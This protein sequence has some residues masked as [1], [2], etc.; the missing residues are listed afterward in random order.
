MSRVLNACFAILDIATSVWLIKNCVAI[1]SQ[2]LKQQLEYLCKQYNSF[3]SS[4]V[5]DSASKTPLLSS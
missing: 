5:N 2:F 1:C 3:H 4:V